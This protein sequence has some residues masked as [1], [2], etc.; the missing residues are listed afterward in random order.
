MDPVTS[1]EETREE[2]ALSYWTE[3]IEIAKGTKQEPWV[4]RAPLLR[5]R[6]GKLLGE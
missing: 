1:D 5:L 2:I 3:E 6:R 4:L